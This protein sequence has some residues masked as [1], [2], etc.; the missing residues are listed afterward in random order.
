MS[1][2]KLCTSVCWASVTGRRLINGCTQNRLSSSVLKGCPK[3]T[4][5]DVVGTQRRLTAHV[6]KGYD[7]IRALR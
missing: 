2:S 7:W 1:F 4:A 5:H 6:L 3:R